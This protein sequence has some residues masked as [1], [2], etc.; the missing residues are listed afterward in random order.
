M[1]KLLIVE[2]EK[3]IRQGLRAIITRSELE[4]EEILECK[5]GEEALNIL[6]EQHID[7]MITDIKMPK[8]NGITLVKSMHELDYQ[9]RT[10]VVSGFEEFNYAVEVLRYGVR[11]YI[12]KPIEREKIIAILK[13]FEAEIIEEETQKDLIHQIGNQ[14][15][16]YLILNKEIQEKEI[17]SIEDR[18]SKL[19][20]H[21]DYV[22]CCCNFKADI[23][24]MIPSSIFLD[25]IEGHKVLILTKEDLAILEDKKARTYCVGVSSIHSGI[26]ELR[27]AYKEAVQSRIEAFV[28]GISLFYHNAELKEIEKVQSEFA[29]QFVQ[30]LGTTKNEFRFSKLEAIMLKAKMGKID[31]AE[32]IYLINDIL[33]KLMQT[34]KNVIELDRTGYGQL[35]NLF[36][37]NNL[38]EYFTVFKE[39]ILQMRQQIL[40]EFEDYRNKE[41]INMAIGYINENYDKNL[42]MAVVSN[43]VSMNY[44]LFSLN[45]KQYTGMNFVNYL[46]MIRINEAKKLLKETEEKIIDISRKVGYDNEK[47]FMKT[48]KSVCGV[49]PTEYRKNALMGNGL[50]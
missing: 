21:K 40:L 32:M 41:K 42:N 13:K 27:T 11:D 34:Y 1:K 5:N 8:M 2:D 10:I 44:S 35:K 12:L 31:A 19:F 38:Q 30:L 29:E 9:P 23:H 39:W 24:N 26:M 47:H 33:D 28:K 50:P 48:F 17:K 36:Q 15:F 6:K 49:S 45:F 14:Q 25:D 22:I 7:V 20:F 3:M 4:I 18:F 16:K 46:K 37:F 43:Y